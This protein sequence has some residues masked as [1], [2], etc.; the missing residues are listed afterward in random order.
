[1]RQNFDCTHHPRAEIMAFYGGDDF[2]G[3]DMESVVWVGGCP[4]D[5]TRR[6]VKHVFARIGL[7]LDAS[8]T[9]CRGEAQAF[10]TWPD[11]F[12]L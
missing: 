7:V 10:V 1:M 11:V 2:G 8:V 12:K 6:E 9:P 5:I 3:D 4:A